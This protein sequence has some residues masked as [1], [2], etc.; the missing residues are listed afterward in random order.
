MKHRRLTVGDRLK[1]QA[2]VSDKKYNITKIAEELNVNK[3]T[4]SRELKNNSEKYFGFNTKCYILPKCGVCN[5]CSKRT[6][7]QKSRLIYNYKT[8]QNKSEFRASGSRSLTRIEPDKIAIVDSI[9]KKGTDLGQSL[10]HIYA[11]NPEL[12]EICSERTIRRMCY[13]GDLTT[14][15]HNLKRYVRYKRE[16]KKTYKDIQ[17]RNVRVLIGRTFEDFLEYIGPNKCKGRV[18]FDSVIGKITDR[19]AILTITFVKESFQFGLVISKGNAESVLY[20]LRNLFRKIGPKYANELFKIN[21]ADNGSEFSRFNEI[22]YDDNGEIQ[23]KTFFTNPY[24]A[25][26]KPYCERNHELIRYV[27]PKGISLNNI[28]Q[29]LLNEI[30][31]NINSYTRKSRN[32]A[33]PYELMERKYGKEFLDL[34]GIRKIDKR[35]VKLVPIA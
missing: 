1:I 8:A 27:F 2:M 10:H 19:K 18:E 4:I 31:S 6:I 14:K 23:R 29:E 3:S 5:S 34:I 11:A 22:E 20:V 12:K 26:D 9:V 24:K 13:R 28:N 25:T 32:D 35:K 33:T 21:L 17:L 16:Y 15:P 7:C 30:F